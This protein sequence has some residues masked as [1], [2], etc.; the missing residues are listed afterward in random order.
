[1]QS[2]C[3]TWQLSSSPRCKVRGYAWQVGAGMWQGTP[4]TT[5]SCSVCS[6]TQ[7][8]ESS[9][10]QTAHQLF[11]PASLTP[12]FCTPPVPEAAEQHRECRIMKREGSGCAELQEA[13]LRQGEGVAR[14]VWECQQVHPVQRVDAL[15]S[16][17]ARDPHVCLCLHIQHTNRGCVFTLRMG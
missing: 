11:A 7:S 15:L 13:A 4:G 14:L 2:A 5:R 3:Q 12:H 10:C 16:H 1:M 6:L 9:G 8:C 17:G